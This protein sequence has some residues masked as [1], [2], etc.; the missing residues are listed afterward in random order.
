MHQ[1]AA[2]FDYFAGAQQNRLGDSKAERFGSL[3]IDCHFEFGRLLNRK[4]RRTGATKNAIDI[5]AERRKMS[6][7]LGP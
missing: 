6:A 2:L 1:S 7:R 5:A 4:L 3:G